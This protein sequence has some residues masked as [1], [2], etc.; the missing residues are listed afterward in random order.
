MVGLIGGNGAGKTT[1]MHCVSGHLRPDQGSIRVFGCDVVGRPAHDRAGLGLLRSFQQ[2]HLFPS[3][4][5]LE[6]AMLA[7]DFADPTD[8][9]SAMASAPWVRWAEER[10]QRD[11][12]AVL[13]TFGLDEHADKS[14]GQLSTGMRRLLQLALVTAPRPRLILLDEPTAGVAQREVEA[15]MPRLASLTAELGCAVLLIE[16][17]V[18]LVMSLCH[19]VYALESGTVLAEGPPEQIRR[20]AR[21]IA[22]YLGADRAVIE[23]SGAGDRD[24]TPVHGALR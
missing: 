15:L 12:R 23:R 10:R 22:S 7:L 20:D 4:T 9:A 19:R 21:V 11:A 17:D 2:A 18:P 1:L 14:V 8:M 24:R 5:V 16:H 6:S 13:E 3:L